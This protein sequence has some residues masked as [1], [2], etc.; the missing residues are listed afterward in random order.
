MKMGLRK[1]DKGFSL[2]EVLMALGILSLVSLGVGVAVSSLMSQ[3]Q[4]VVTSDIGDN[5][6]A[7]FFQHLLVPVNCNAAIN[8]QALPTSGNGTPLIVHS[9]G[10]EANPALN[11]VQANTQVD[12]GLFV[13]S[14]TIRQKP[15]TS[16]QI[17]QIGSNNQRDRRIAQVVLKLERR[18]P[19]EAPRPYPDRILEIPVLLPAGGGNMQECQL[20]SDAEDLCL[21]MGGTYQNDECIPP[22][23]CSMK[24]TYIQTTCSDNS[25]GCANEYTGGDRNNTFTGGESCPEGSCPTQSG[26]FNITRSVQTGKKSSKNI[27]VYENFYIC[28]SC[29][30][31]T[32]PSSPASTPAKK[33]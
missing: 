23:Q 14:L 31:M 25:Y 15:G 11:V 28:M 21:S 12:R 26:R 10:G 9:F 8:N 1:H 20:E 4:Q 6:S 5:F 3:Q 30:G 7:A 33:N 29:P 32:C 2:V 16:G 17:I 24:G 18:P 27:T 22:T 19:N 13:N